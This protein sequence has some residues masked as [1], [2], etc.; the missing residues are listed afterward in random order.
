MKLSTKN[1]WFNGRRWP[2]HIGWANCD[3]D[4]AY[5]DGG[6]SPAMN[7]GPYLHVR[8]VDPDDE[9]WARIYPRKKAKQIAR[10]GDEWH[11]A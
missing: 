1:T 6:P 10:I 2:P 4:K 3:F 11:A 9:V 8:I 5:V 7:N